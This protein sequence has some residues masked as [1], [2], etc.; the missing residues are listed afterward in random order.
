MSMNGPRTQV[1]KYPDGRTKQCF[2][3]ECDINAIMA[4]A[5]QGGTISHL[6]KNKGTYADFSDYDF[7]E[8]T[9][10]LT[11][12]REIF[13]DLPA[14][15]RREFGQSPQ[16]FFDYVNDPAN[17]DKLEQKLPDLAKPGTQLPDVTPLDADAQKA[18][19]KKDATATP[20]DAPTSDEPKPTAED[21]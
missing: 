12:G 14:E 11:R 6:E 4:R 2:K 16:R 10:M 21:G 3:D 1:T 5:A 18:K 8:A 13:D 9:Q 19:D 17:K 7:F 15:V 20:Q